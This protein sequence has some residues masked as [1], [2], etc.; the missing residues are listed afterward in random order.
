[1]DLNQFAKSIKDPGVFVPVVEH[2]MTPGQP[3]PMAGPASKTYA[4]A[5]QRAVEAL[6]TGTFTKG[7]VVSDSTVDEVTV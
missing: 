5:R 7:W 2:R 4:D 6:A 1:M 3:M